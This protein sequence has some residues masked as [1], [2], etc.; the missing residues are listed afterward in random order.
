M[1]E[2][3]GPAVTVVVAVYNTMPYLT[4]CL[5]SLVAQ[6][7][8]A[9]QLE[10]IAVDDGSTDGGGAEL[11]R[12]ARLHPDIF[13]VLHQP[14]SGGPAV[15]SNRA[16]DQANGRYVFFLGADDYLGPEA[17]EEQPNTATAATAAQIRRVST[18]TAMIATTTSPSSNGLPNRPSTREAGP[19]RMVS[20]T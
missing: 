12:F 10:V 20:W 11:D 17:L 15:P 18:P 19:S 2:A 8:G 1:S 13:T 9:G 4:R 5:E 6:T 3:Q 16:L 7:I 14:N